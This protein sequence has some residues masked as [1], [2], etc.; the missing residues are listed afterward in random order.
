[1]KFSFSDSV[2]LDICITIVSYLLYIVNLYNLFITQGIPYRNQ[3]LTYAFWGFP[4]I[5][6]LFAAKNFIRLSKGQP[7]AKLFLA[8]HLSALILFV[9]FFLMI[10]SKA[11]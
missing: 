7:A 5:C 6:I 11:A 3:L 1:M 8:I 9:S 4:L 10:F 2:F